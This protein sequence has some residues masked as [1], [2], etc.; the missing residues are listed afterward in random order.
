MLPW[1][2]RTLSSCGIAFAKCRRR[3][4]FAPLD[5]QIAASPLQNIDVDKDSPPWMPRTLFSCGIAFAKCRCGAHLP[6]ASPVRTDGLLVVLGTHSAGNLLPLGEI[7][8]PRVGVTRHG[9]SQEFRCLFSWG[10]VA[11]E[12]V[13]HPG[14]LPLAC[15]GNPN[16]IT[17]N[18]VKYLCN[19]LEPSRE[20]PGELLVIATKLFLSRDIHGEV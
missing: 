8:H 12:F 13:G 11:G 15:C 5:A 10:C 6:C 18:S 19:I 16:S 17:G 1:I 14:G 9:G 20:C 2:P 4:G 3:Q 7:P